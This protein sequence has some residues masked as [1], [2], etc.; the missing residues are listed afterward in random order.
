MASKKKTIAAATAAVTAAAAVG[1]VALFGGGDPATDQA[2]DP[3]TVIQADTNRADLDPLAQYRAE[4]I[5]NGTKIYYYKGVPFE[6]MNRIIEQG[7]I[8][9]LSLE[10]EAVMY[11]MSDVSIMD[12]YI[13]INTANGLKYLSAISNGSITDEQIPTINFSG[14]NV[15]LNA[16]LDKITD[17]EPFSEFNGLFYGNGMDITVSN[18]LFESFGGRLNELTLYSSKPAARRASGGQVEACSFYFDGKAEEFGII[19]EASGVSVRNTYVECS[20]TGARVGGIFGVASGDC[21]IVN[22]IVNGTLNGTESVGSFIGVL[23]NMITL[24]NNSA[25]TTVNAL[26][27]C[28]GKAIGSV[29]FEYKDDTAMI[30]GLYCNTALTVE[31]LPSELLI[32]SIPEEV[33]E[34]VET[35]VKPEDMEGS[36]YLN[37]IKENSFQVI[38]CED[39][40]DTIYLFDWDAYE[41]GETVTAPEFNPEYPSFDGIYSIKDLVELNKFAEANDLKSFY[42]ENGRVYFETGQTGGEGIYFENLI[43]SEGDCVAFVS[44]D[45]D[46]AAL[47]VAAYAG[48][49]LCSMTEHD[50]T[51]DGVYFVNLEHSEEITEIKAFLWSSLEEMTPLCEAGTL[52]TV[53]GEE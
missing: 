13:F 7:G 3:V 42:E 31:G 46:N 41:V 29:E 52:G 24:L 36:D 1:G 15:F 23:K 20:I 34:L 44:G 32:G 47:I 18:Y 28:G 5:V 49:R 16:A 38:E 22:C 10:D 17:F 14:F 43:Y 26:T 27:G 19:G 9:M 12:T 39:W 8:N 21:K 51:G 35:V 25:N 2:T 4:K 53:Y 45:F 11:E 30:N 40:G 6:L 48:D 37:W 33:P 50:I